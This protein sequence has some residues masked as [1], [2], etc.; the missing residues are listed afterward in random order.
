MGYVVRTGVHPIKRSAVNP[1]S[2][3]SS[4][5]PDVSESMSCWF[6]MGCREPPTSSAYPRSPRLTI[7][8]HSVPNP[9]PSY[10]LFDHSP[11]QKEDPQY[12]KDR[13][14]WNRLISR[15]ETAEEL[16]RDYERVTRVVLELEALRSRGPCW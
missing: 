14:E 2:V 10:L 16:F 12:E 7:K 15:D 13:A 4:N 1:R 11:Q 6:K 5:P 8:T 3:R 9:A